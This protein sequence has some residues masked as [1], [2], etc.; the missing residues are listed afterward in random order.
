MPNKEYWLQQNL[1]YFPNVRVAE[2]QNSI[3]NMSD[4]EFNMLCSVEYKDP[5]IILIL[6][7]FCFDRF[8]L[9][10]VGL[11]IVKIITGGG[12]GVWWILDMVSAQNRAK[13]F[14]YNQYISTINMY[15]GNKDLSYSSQNKFSA[16]NVADEIKK[17]KLLLD[18]GIITEEEFKKKKEELL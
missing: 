5:T 12:C 4:Q 11:G 1:K 2:I 10:D 9:D 18:Q 14:N 3:Q 13:E 7:I 15:G 6:A 17:Y 16:E 8:L